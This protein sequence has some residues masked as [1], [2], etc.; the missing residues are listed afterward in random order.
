MN[1]ARFICHQ[2]AHGRHH[3]VV[4]GLFQILNRIQRGSASRQQILCVVYLC[5]YLF[6]IHNT[7][8]IEIGRENTQKST[9]QIQA[10]QHTP[11]LVWC[12]YMLLILFCQ[13][14]TCTIIRRFD[15][16]PPV[17]HAN[18]LLMNDISN[19]RNKFTYC[20]KTPT[21]HIVPCI[22]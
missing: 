4:F 7:S 20:D 11:T 18:C 12:I 21:I 3:A 14:P 9:K 10:H 1:D 16:S 8:V 19:E 6:V 22:V 5:Y 2:R 15:L 17:P 13:F